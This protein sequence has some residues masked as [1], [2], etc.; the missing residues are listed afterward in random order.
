M[1]VL[2]VNFTIA[3]RNLM[4][5]KARSLLTL[6]GLMIGVLAVISIVSLG[7]GLKMMFA[8]QVAGMGNDV[9]FAIPD[10]PRRA[11]QSSTTVRARLFDMDDV[12]ALEKAGG[13]LFLSVSPAYEVGGTAKYMENNKFVVVEGSDENFLRNF[14][15]KL[16]R[17]R[18]FDPGDLSARSRVGVLGSKVVDELFPELVDPIGKKIKITRE[19]FGT[20]TVTIIGTLKEK[21][22]GFGG[23][24]IDDCVLIPY[25]TVQSRFYGSKKV[26][27]IQIKVADMSKMDEAK[28]IVEKVLR[29]QRRVTDPSMDS[30]QVMFISD[31]LDFANTFVNGL[32]TVFGVIAVISLL[33]G[34]I[35]IMNIMLVSVTE[36]TR[37]IGLRMALGARRVVILL[38]FLIEAVVLTFMGGIL[39]LLGGIG[40]GFGVAKWLGSM[41]NTEWNVHLPVPIILL[42]LLVSSLIGI[43]FGV[44]PAFKASR[45]DPIEALRYE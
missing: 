45:L 37:E 27:Y 8:G 9:M 41:L 7:E 24:S 32:V 5:N 19:S 16:D 18:V 23:Q 43:F 21:G 40:A 35:G 36:R 4:M 14:G 1:T 34:G 31:I 3:W 2:L 20:Q 15:L 11:G 42:T 29:K 22:G 25:T 26:P 13:E 39:G 12:T 17:G 44:Y 6:L 30:F 28:A 10:P 33:V 38:Q